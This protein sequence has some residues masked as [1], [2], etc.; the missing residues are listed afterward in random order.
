MGWKLDELM[1]ILPSIV[2]CTAEHDEERCSLNKSQPDKKYARGLALFILEV[3][4]YPDV[5]VDSR[6]PRTVLATEEN[7]HV[8]APFFSLPFDTHTD[9]P[10]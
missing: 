10:S 1:T 5:L 3:I 4:C 6:F 9:T 8:F 7:Q 2:C